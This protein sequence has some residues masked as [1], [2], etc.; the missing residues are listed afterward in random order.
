ME[1]DSRLLRYFVAVAEE[2]SFSRAA[3]RLHLS[4]PPLSHAIRQ[5]EDNLGVRLFERSSRHVALTPAG[6]A[7]YK[8]AR[9]LLQRNADVRQLVRRI[10]AGLEGEVKIGFVGSMLYRGL[11]AW[12]TH[13]QSRYPGVARALQELNSAEQIGLVARGGLDIG[14]VHANP[15]TD[16]LTAETLLIEPFVLCLP[17]GHALAGNGHVDLAVLAGE[18]FIFFASALSPVYYELLLRMC[19][20]AGFMPT[21]RYEARHWLSAVSLVA[22]GM[23]VSIVPR[24][25]AACG[26]EGVAYLRFDHTQRSETQMI[27][28]RG[29]ASRIV[30]NHLDL[31]R[32][33]FAARAG[34]AAD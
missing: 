13:C 25:L 8:E 4:Q 21:V 27:W 6:Q 15:V 33:W 31:L 30:H 26:L 32:D 10:H 34:P 24:S 28:A 9:F 22:Q 16:E 23:G 18:P 29:S 3:A 20:D 5:L 1:I 11:P 12:L 19:L 17:A 2:L 7:L 14:L